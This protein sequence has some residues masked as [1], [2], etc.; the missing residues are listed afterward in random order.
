[1][2]Q[3]FTLNAETLFRS[4]SITK[5]PCDKNHILVACFPKGGS[6]WL[7]E[8]L[9]QLPGYTRVDFVPLHDRREQELAFERLVLYH[10]FN[11][12]AQHHCRFSRATQRSLD[13][14]SI[15]P[16]ILIRNVFDCV[17]SAKEYMDGGETDRD[18]M[19]GPMA[20]VPDDYFYWSDANKYSFIIDMMVPWYFNFFLGWKD[21]AGGNWVTY[22]ALLAK[23]SDV[24]RSISDQFEL[25]LND[26]DIN[27][28]LVS[29]SQRPTRKNVAI[30]GRGEMLT[31]GHKDKIRN[32]A[33][34]YPKHDFSQIGL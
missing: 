16:V 27:V 23:P 1:M 10:S 5:L 13:A 20:Y 28:A 9:S 4:I 2:S 12:V 19:L 6:T 22:E 17:V 18:R 34:Y 14:F 15:K 33:G 32:F 31:N 7:S 30:A 24:I 29:A 8:I 21:Y 26:S 11:Y 25:G 3:T